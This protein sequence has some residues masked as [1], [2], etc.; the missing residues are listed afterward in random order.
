MSLIE[1]ATTVGVLAIL[2][3]TLVPALSEAR[4]EGKEVRCLSNLG[5]LA[6]ASAIY[7]AADRSEHAIPVHPLI[8]VLSPIMGAITQNVGAATAVLNS[9]RLI[10]WSQ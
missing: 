2:M 5:Q 6:D 4:R 7:S 10:R 8:G 3:A 9:A 1:L